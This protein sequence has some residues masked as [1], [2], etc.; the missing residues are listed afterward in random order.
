MFPIPVFHGRSALRVLRNGVASLALLSAVLPAAGAAEQTPRRNVAR[1]GTSDTMLARSALAALDA[2]SQLK[3]LSVVVSVVD[4]VAVIGGSVP[5]PDAGKR[6]EEIVRNI[7]GI[8]DVKNRCFVQSQPDPLIRAVTE[9]L[10]PTVRRPS[11]EDLPGMVRPPRPR[12]LDEAY[13]PPP[14]AV[15]AASTPVTKPTTVMKI[16]STTPLRPSLLLDPVSAPTGPRT[17]APSFVP[18][19][20]TVPTRLTTVAPQRG[21]DTASQL[22]EIRRA[23]TRYA[24]LLFEM[25]N[26][27]VYLTGYTPRDGDAWDFADAA[28]RVPGVKQVVVGPMNR[29]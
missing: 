9:R 28:R 22:S 29:R 24:N 26:G 16:S 12:T 5:S 4:R 21:T 23:D 13:A 19:T 7:S 18:A 15:A 11:S 25:R 3:D 10:N 8:T 2:D 1:P 14:S 17:V 6:A 20:G 27:V